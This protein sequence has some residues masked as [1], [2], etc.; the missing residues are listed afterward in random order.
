MGTRVSWEKFRG[1]VISRDSG[2]VNAFLL[3]KSSGM[4]G[5]VDYGGKS[6]FIFLM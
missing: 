6:T 5:V 2:M 1:Q 4:V 3:D